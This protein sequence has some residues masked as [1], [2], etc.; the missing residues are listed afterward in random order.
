MADYQ[1][2]K[3]SIE[4]FALSVKKQNLTIDV[5]ISD[6]EKEGET[7]GANQVIRLMNDRD[8]Q[9]LTLSGLKAQPSDYSTKYI[10]TMESGSSYMEVGI[11][12]DFAMEIIR[13]LT[14]E[15]WI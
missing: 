9:E 15:G 8:N 13:K 5:H 11:P 10:L 4:S 12:E 3:D 2:E 1:I 7:S 6:A 14:E